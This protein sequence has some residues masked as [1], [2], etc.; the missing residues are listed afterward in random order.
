MQQVLHRPYTMRC[1]S[2]NSILQRIE[3]Q[4][5]SA[6]EAHKVIHRCPKCPLDITKFSNELS[7]SH[8]HL[9][10]TIRKRNVLPEVD[11][12]AHS[13]MVIVCVTTKNR[14]I[15]HDVHSVK[16]ICSNFIDLSHRVFKGY[17]SG[18]W[19]GRMISIVS[20][21]PLGANISMQTVQ[22]LDRVPG[23]YPKYCDFEYIELGSDFA[24]LKKDSVTLCKMFT[25]E[26]TTN[27]SDWITSVY[28]MGTQPISLANH[29]NNIKLGAISNITARAY[30]ASSV[31][32]DSYLFST[33][34]DGERLWMTRLGMVWVFS[35]RLMDHTIQGWI[36]DDFCHMQSKH[37]IGPILDVEILWGHKAIL[38][39]VLM[40]EHGIISSHDRT[41][42]WI[43][44]KF[45]F[46]KTQFSAL[47]SIEAR[48]FY[49]SI[50][51]ADTY[52]KSVDY[53]TDGLVA[54][55]K[56]G[57]DMLKLKPIKSI[58][59][60]FIQGG[61]FV[62]REG[63]K[64]F[65]TLETD[66]YQIG[67][68]VEIRISL[69]AGQPLIHKNF[70][71]PD[72]KVANSDSVIDSILRSCEESTSKNVIRTTIWRWSNSLRLKL[73]E[74][75]S[76]LMKDK[77]IILDIG[78]GS[79]QSTEA[80]SKIPNASFILVE[81]DPHKCKLLAKRLGVRNIDKDPRSFIP[82]IPQLKRGNK[83]Y[84]IINTTLQE[85][86][87][88]SVA[89]MNMIGIVGCMI[90]SFSIHFIHDCLEKIIE[91][92]VP[93]IG[94]YYS[95]DDIPIGKCIIDDSDLVMKRVSKDTATVQWG[96][97]EIYNEPVLE[98]I[99]LPFGID[100]LDGSNMISIP[101][102]NKTDPIYCACSHVKI[103]IWR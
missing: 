32:N 15:S 31:T 55:S 19:K 64:L 99:N 47:D 60:E 20:E 12:T 81:P 42:D 84:H 48:P 103:L 8:I 33:K 68:I 1:I 102:S 61:Y 49:S 66:V 75:A 85:I 17:V 87:A 90:S 40:D 6:D 59:L 92:K 54:V 44:E 9:G 51:S 4:A 86:L 58:E 77:H 93:F 70:V 67:S 45:E 94:S 91:S 22:V 35:R 16:A 41:L 11:S 14:F 2:C 26:D 95:Y 63:T 62:T 28:L 76:I 30:D 38:I 5:R 78:S 34:P 24:I 3:Y 53:P 69:E 10:K 39:D 101:V 37:M 50:A 46:L 25:T 82:L 74:R 88:D 89:T 98:M 7:K 73:Y 80:F 65:Q 29:I 97:D 72:K 56:T 79:G 57:T 43:N 52:R 36:I 27:I 23:S 71:R 96:R 21:I 100:V 83:T 13:C 18:P